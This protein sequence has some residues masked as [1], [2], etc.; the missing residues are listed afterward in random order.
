MGQPKN[1][2]QAIL[3]VLESIDAKLEAQDNTL[4]NQE[5]QS[6]A[7]NKNLQNM[8]A[9]G[10]VSE[11]EYKT[12]AKF[13][14][15][16]A[17]GISTL[18][19]VADKISAK[20][21]E[22]IKN[23]L[24]NVGEGI[25]A[26]FKEV[27][28]A[29]VEAFTKF[30]SSLGPSILKFALA[31]VIATPL[32]IIAP[33]GALLFGLSI[34]AILWAM[35]EADEK[36]KEAIQGLDVILGLGGGILLFAL[37]M[38]LFLPLS[39]LVLLGSLM[40][41]LTIRALM[42]SIGMSAENGKE[43]AAGLTAI[44]DLAKGILLFALAMVVYVLVSPIVL[45]GAVMFGLTMR[46]LL[47]IIGA[48][49]KKAKQ[50]A[51]A[52]E[53][54]LRLAK[55]ILLFALAMIVVTLLFPVVL[56]GALFFALSLWIISLG[57]NVIGSK[58]AQRGVRALLITVIA[59]ALMALVFFLAQSVLTWEGIAMVLVMVAG[60]ALVM[61]LA[62]MF[63]K[64]IMKG[65]IAMM[66]AAI[67]II[68]LSVAMMIWKAANVG[69]MDIA[70]LGATVVGLAV[71]MGLLGMYESGLM[72]G[73]PLTITI[74][75]AAMIVASGAIIV[76]SIG[77]L[78][79]K[80][81]AVTWAD[82]GIL[83]A[84]VGMIGVEMALLGLAS[85][86]IFLGS[87]AMLVAAA[88]LL[89]ISMSLM[90]FKKAGWQGKK[91]DDALSGALGAIVNGF[92]GGPMPGGILAAIKFAAKAAA[93]AALLFITV[94]PM[95]LAG[96]ALLPISLALLTF[97]KAN[98][99][100]KDASNMEFAI[101][102]VIKAFSLPGDYQ[103]QKEL[104]IYTSP[105]QIYLGIM[106][107]KNAGS[108]LVSLA[109]GIQ[110]FANLTV[111]IY[112]FNEEKG[113]LQIVDRRQMNEA[114]FD[115]AAYG[116]AKVITSIAE[117]FALVGRLD[118]GEPSGNPFYD[119]IFGGGLVKRG[120]KALMGAGNILVDL[121][122]AVQ[123]FAN[124]TVSRYELRGE[125]ADAKLV[126]VER[127]PMDA[128]MFDLAAANMGKIVDVMA[129]VFAKVGKAEADSSGWFSGGYVTK[130]VKALTGSGGIMVDLA[131]SVQ[132]FAN[133]TV[134]RWE[135]VEGK[136]G[137]ELKEVERRSMTES[138][139]Q[140]ATNNMRR[141]VST[142]M[143]VFKE[144]GKAE[145]EGGWFFSNNYVSKGIA[146][147]AGAGETIS[148][149][150][151]GVQK[152]ANMQFIT[153]TVKDN[154]VVPA[155]VSNISPA[156]V[157]MAGVNM[158]LIINTL[159]NG[160]KYAGELYEQNKE[161]IDGA[162]EKASSVMNGISNYASAMKKWEEADINYEKT[163]A[164]M[165]HSLITLSNALAVLMI[166]Y[167]LNKEGWDQLV[168]R[169][170][171]VQ[172]SIMNIVSGF[173]FWQKQS[174]PIEYANESLPK[175]FSML[176]SVFTKFGNSLT[177]F[178]EA[179]IATY[180]NAP[181]IKKAIIQITTGFMF[182]QKANVTADVVG[183]FARWHEEISRMFG[184]KQNP[185]LPTQ[186][187]YFTKFTSNVTKLAA[188]AK[189]WKTIAEGMNS[190]ADGMER[191]TAS[192]N[193]ADPK[194]LQMMDSLMASLAILGK[195]NGL[196][197]LGAE[198]GEGI[199]VGLEKFAEK[200]AELINEA[201]GGGG[202]GGGFG[203]D[204]NP[205]D[206]DGIGL[207]PKKPST[208]PGPAGPPAQ[209]PAQQITPQAIANA[210]KSALASTTIKVKSTNVTGDKVSF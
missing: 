146:A 55:G 47:W 45:I 147:L 168:E 108:T 187:M 32:L 17:K 200:I 114:D 89:P 194:N 193:A 115:K 93:R 116:M 133:L 4:K 7:L 13:F 34:R 141:I 177:Q 161:S 183:T 9:T 30:L 1:I 25:Q 53:S 173:M 83:G 64:D 196:E 20:A 186:T 172:K 154:K 126:E 22:N 98:F 90:I 95:I 191:Y 24:T 109:E 44:L 26:F 110:A 74:G 122:K 153:Y 111:P 159:M 117:P 188:Q 69:W 19:K 129:G 184:P 134:S 50:T 10:V 180:I 202:G 160:L 140:S 94:P 77:M 132:D 179:W 88:A 61:Y 157:L 182:W 125:G 136:D 150:A 65:S 46:L 149:I 52:M 106:S 15:E 203:L 33:I 121:A 58:K 76:L 163:P 137:G 144:V 14:G 92:L 3:S 56:V 105:L 2:N 99:G 84:T 107:L 143:D 176:E 48:S 18:V 171:E 210:L 130:G 21:A 190:T 103:R 205:F 192:I 113:E 67:P 27:D 174:E 155:G 198:I 170:G 127:I 197:Q 16:M 207:K 40:F 62:G 151:D 75:S 85:P 68:L 23:V 199:Q 96:M 131:K 201:G 100:K 178:K 142:V 119:A 54:V 185:E 35:G 42:W 41:G 181:L 78:L 156:K 162:I 86:L 208:N 164:G 8:A 124:L 71:V 135:Y 37:A 195:D 138:D 139:F 206:G 6:Q 81:A 169:S 43:V 204:L 175:T 49:G 189:V 165:L 5:K 209:K 59:I 31:M 51:R 158:K 57:L 38:V 128:G 36:Q 87:A 63:Q 11:D 148:Q 112:K 123:S 145:S 29:T 101:G 79:W 166:S 167:K 28:P 12:F 72:T 97:K 102:A 82:V 152:M 120:V 104:G 118:K 80:A 91:D 66:V 70:I 73:I 60:V 39:P